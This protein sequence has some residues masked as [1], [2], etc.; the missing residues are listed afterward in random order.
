MGVDRSSERM[1]EE[2][3]E[4]LTDS[5]S[6]RERERKR[7]RGHWKRRAGEKL[8]EWRYERLIETGNEKTG[9]TNTNGCTS[10]VDEEAVT[11]GKRINMNLPLRGHVDSSKWPLGTWACLLRVDMV[12]NWA[13]THTR[14]YTCRLQLHRAGETVK[15]A[16][17]TSQFIVFAGQ[18]RRRK[19]ISDNHTECRR[20]IKSFKKKKLHPANVVLQK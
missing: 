5:E 1:M 3:G 14:G 16:W 11:S 6:R 15:H 17:K 4:G 19:M 20:M 12:W 9:D 7:E 2:E 13:H 18:G 8:I 10:A